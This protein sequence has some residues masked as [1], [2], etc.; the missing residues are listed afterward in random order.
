MSAALREGPSYDGALYWTP[1]YQ[2]PPP[3]PTAGGSVQHV[4]YQ[5]PHPMYTGMMPQPGHPAVYAPPPAPL[6]SNRVYPAAHGL[7]AYPVPL[8][9]HSIAQYGPSAYV[10]HP[11]QHR[12]F[13]RDGAMQQQVQSR[14]APHDYRSEGDYRNWQQQQ[15]Q[16]QDMAGGE[17][18]SSRLPRMAAVV[19]APANAQKA[20]AVDH[21]HPSFDRPPH[22]SAPPA[23]VPRSR[24]PSANEQ[25]VASNSAIAR[26]INGEPVEYDLVP[27][28]S[29]V[30]PP[31]PIERSAVPLA[32]LAVHMVWEACALGVAYLDGALPADATGLSMSSRMTT[33]LRSIAHNVQRPQQLRASPGHQ[34]LS[35]PHTPELYGAIGDGRLRKVSRMS[36]DDGYMSGDS[37]PSSSAPGTPADETIADRRRRLASMGL[38]NND[39]DQSCDSLS[40]DDPIEAIVRA[41]QSKTSMS[42]LHPSEPTNAFRQF[43]KQVLTAT[44]VAPEDL[45]LALLFVARMP[46][47]LVLP[48]TPP[49]P[50]S[51][52]SDEASA[53]KAAPFKTILG[54]LMLANKTL[55]DNSYRNETFAS[56]SG[57]PLS[58]V[59][60]IEMFVYSALNFDTAVTDDIWR[61]WLDFVVDRS[62]GNGNLGQR[63]DVHAALRRLSRA[64]DRSAL[65]SPVVRSSPIF[66]AR[67]VTPPNSSA[68]AIAHVNLDASGPLESPLHYDGRKQLGPAPSPV[69]WPTS[70]VSS[71]AGSHDLASAPKPFAFGHCLPLAVGVS[72]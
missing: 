14:F 11:S 27:N 59:N 43:V 28:I 50:G 51:N 18:L 65:V 10:Q 23:L 56:V 7:H 22:R 53:I 46:C 6:L 69:R 71:G 8:P 31:P 49:E 32:D 45:V 40:V 42:R 16:Q 34:Q 63:V 35:H 21:D 20:D 72:C 62:L 68:S 26:A 19:R 5:A 55:Q 54:A 47:S 58:D 66:A 36:L 48:S 67:P 33:L 25:S 44:L 29:P 52:L 41:E 30:P 37:S 64:T 70:R 38:L 24:E 15:Q 3:Y 57:I 61:S 13:H 9:D 60:Q 2:Q 39:A 1:L 17:L 4:H 12:S